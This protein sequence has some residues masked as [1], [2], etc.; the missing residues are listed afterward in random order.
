MPLQ[1]RC[2][3]LLSWR[4][5]LKTSQNVSNAQG[6]E[7]DGIARFKDGWTYKPDLRTEPLRGLNNTPIG[8]PREPS[9]EVSQAG[10]GYY[11]QGT[12]SSCV[13]GVRV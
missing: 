10:G 9:R 11:Q 4:N 7:V 6:S 12:I 13:G 1:L 3:R 8:G 5:I 2:S